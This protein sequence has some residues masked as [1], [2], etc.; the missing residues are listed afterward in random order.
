MGSKRNAHSSNSFYSNNTSTRQNSNSNGNNTNNGSLN[1]S[2]NNNIS[3]QNNEGGSNSSSHS[4]KHNSAKDKISRRSSKKM[5]SIVFDS[6]NNSNN[7]DNVTRI[8]LSSFDNSILRKYKDTY[9]IKTKTNYTRDDL[10]S[11]VT[12]HWNSQDI[13]EKDII[14]QFIYTVRN[15]GNLLRLP[16]NL[17]TTKN[18]SSKTKSTNN[19]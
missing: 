16:L 15:H 9:K 2:G 6:I 8:N 1:S 10:L 19:N 13:S 12:K 11:A 14:T 7:N 17:T 5:L 18:Q 4:L 3:Y